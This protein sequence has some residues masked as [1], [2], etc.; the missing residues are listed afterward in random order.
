MLSLTCSGQRHSETLY[1]DEPRGQRS[2]AFPVF[3]L[4][5]QWIRNP[6]DRQRATKREKNQYLL[7]NITNC[8][9]S[10]C[11]AALMMEKHHYG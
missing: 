4:T 1:E 8:E 10:E 7:Y 9:D 11:K 3:Q 6:T 2:E 5:S